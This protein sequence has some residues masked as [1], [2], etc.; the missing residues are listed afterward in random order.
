[1]LLELIELAGPEPL[2]V[3]HPTGDLPQWLAA[4]RDEDFASLLPALDEASAFE[5][6]E[7]LRHRIERRVERFRDIEESRRSLRRESSNDR[8]A[9]RVSD[10]REYI[11]ELVHGRY[12]T[13][14][15]N[16]SN[17]RRG[18]RR[19]VAT[20]AGGGQRTAD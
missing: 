5:Q 17:G 3:V 19:V 2:V 7:M 16:V 8:P 10:R 11:R 6:L 14:R 12:Y 18:R 1:M 13:I 4:K 9:R 15:C 20:M